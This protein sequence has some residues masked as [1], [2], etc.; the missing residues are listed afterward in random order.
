MIAVVVLLA[1]V[2]LR[3]AVLCG[4]ALLLI[5]PGRRCPACGAETA[6]LERTGLAQ[7][8]PRVERRWCV[9][10]GWSWFRKR[11]RVLAV[12]AAPARSVEKG[13]GA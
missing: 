6:V 11:S 1:L 10:C 8:L 13:V 9:E 12:T 2:A 3:V 7:L 4:I 5:P